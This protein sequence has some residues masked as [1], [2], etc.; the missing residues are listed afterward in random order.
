MDQSVTETGP[1]GKPL[2]SASRPP[3]RL[4][5]M[6]GSQIPP[7]VVLGC[8]VGRPTQPPETAAALAGA[9]V[10]VG[11][12]RLLDAFPDHPGRR[13]PIAGPLAA[14]CDAVAAAREA[15]ESVVVLADGDGLFFGVGATLLARFG[16]QALRFHPNV[17]TV[18]AACSRLGRSWDG[19]PVVSLHG[20]IGRAHV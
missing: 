2:F 1:K 20:Q 9:A 13:I 16:A 18:A 7:I 3:D 4:G 10:L 15:G 8:G 12:R 6:T 14:V 5:S 17:T 11:G 19:L